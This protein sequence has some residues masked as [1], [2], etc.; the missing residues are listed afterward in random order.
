MAGYLPQVYPLRHT[1]D[2]RLTEASY[3]N[4]TVAGEKRGLVYRISDFLH[5][6]LYWL[7]SPMVASSVNPG[8]TKL[9]VSQQ[10]PSIHAL[11]MKPLTLGFSEDPGNLD[12]YP[13]TLQ[14]DF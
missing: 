3:L 13:Q 10:Y 5:Q 1:K 6:G 14:V 12:L 4:L 7:P 9:T 8:V 11:S 2:L